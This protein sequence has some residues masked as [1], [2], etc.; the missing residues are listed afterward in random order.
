MK[1]VLHEIELSADDVEAGEKFYNELLDLRIR[2]DQKDLKVF[3]S[4]AQG[5]NFDISIHKTGKTSVSFLTDDLDAVTEKLKS[6]GVQF[7]CPCATH[8]GMKSMILTDPDA[9]CVVINTPTDSSPDW[10]K[11]IV[12]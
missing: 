6:H 1:L 5:L 7:D 8:P 3:D 11:K 12:G 10:L 2:Q 9:H 4:G